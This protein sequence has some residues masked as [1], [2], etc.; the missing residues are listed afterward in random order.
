MYPHLDRGTLGPIIKYEEDLVRLRRLVAS[1]RRRIVEENTKRRELISWAPRII[2]QGAWDPISDP[3]SLDGA[4]SLPMPVEFAEPESLAPFLQHLAVNGK[5]PNVSTIDNGTT[6]SITEPYYQT[7]AIEF[8]R[9]VE[10]SDGRMDLCKMVLGPRNIA[11]LMDSLKTNQSVTHFLLGNNIIGPSG[12]KCI[13]DFLKEFRNRMDTW[14][15]A[16]NCIDGPSLRLLVDEWVNSTSVTN[17]WLKRNP[18]GPAAAGD[19]FQLVTQT[20]NL[21]TLDL[22]QTEL[23]DAG[24]TELFNK[25][26]VHDRPIALRHIYL[27]AVG[28]GEKAA[29]AIAKYLA[30]PLCELAALYASNNPLGDAGVAA[31]AHG[32]KVNTSLTRLTLASV[33]VND[34]GIIALCNALEKHPSLVTLD[35]GQS[36]STEDLEARYN[37]VTDHSASSLHSFVASS[38]K[39]A[40]L[41]LSQC[42]MTNIGL[43]TLLEAVS[44]SPTLLFYRAIKIW[45]QGRD[46]VAIHAGQ[47][48]AKL[49]EQAH[50]NV[51]K[52]IQRT[53]GDNFTHE[54]FLTEHKRWLV[55]DKT[56]VRKIDSV[57]RNRDAG[58]ARRGLKTLDKW[59]D[60]NNQQTLK[61]AMGAVGP[62]CTMRKNK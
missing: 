47:Q 49:A 11:A 45:P 14:Y 46:P 6:V 7:P 27:N 18:L 33:G 10:Y 37:W 21:R 9:G 34:A 8:E 61:E 25:L 58:L 2:K 40:Y 16:G 31:L 41:N 60:E 51:L 3:V 57:Y 12:A 4:P 54:K 55:N 15:L 28:V 48:H 44:N 35:I 43:S 39:L 24:V 62:V 32:L 1:Q 56:D 5:V 23:G 53:Y 52:N 30:S 59:W 29:G 22:D 50:A 42:A 38:Q 26:A 19:I 17:I 20:D 13:A 36:Y